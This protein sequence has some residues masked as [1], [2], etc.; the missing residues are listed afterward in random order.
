MK[1]CRDQKRREREQ[2]EAWAR[3]HGVSPPENSTKVKKSTHRFEQW[4]ERQLKANRET[5]AQS[6]DFALNENYFKSDADKAENNQSFGGSSSGG[7]VPNEAWGLMKNGPQSWAS[8]APWKFHI[9]VRRVVQFC[10]LASSGLEDQLATLRQANIQTMLVK[11]RILVDGASWVLCFLPSDFLEVACR[12]EINPD[13]LS[14]LA[15]TQYEEVQAKITEKDPMLL[16]SLV[17]PVDYER[18]RELP[19]TVFGSRSSGS[20]V[21]KKGAGL[22]PGAVL[23]K[24]VTY[25]DLEVQCPERDTIESLEG[26]VTRWLRTAAGRENDPN[27]PRS[28]HVFWSMQEYWGA[29]EQQEQLS[30]PNAGTGIQKL[31]SLISK[32]RAVGHQVYVCVYAGIPH[33]KTNPCED[34]QLRLFEESVMN[35]V[36]C[37]GSEALV[38][39]GLGFWTEH[40]KLWEDNGWFAI[41]TTENERAVSQVLDRYIM[42]Q[43]TILSLTIHPE[44]VE[45][46][47]NQV[48]LRAAGIRLLPTPWPVQG[49]T[50]P[51]QEYDAFDRLEPMIGQESDSM[52]SIDALLHDNTEI[53]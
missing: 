40:H 24:Y 42:R 44:C 43:K 4:L 33:I 2:N 19:I 12:A 5:L 26:L 7:P 36:N 18:M 15:Q 47:E 31:K 32:L 17:E 6:G 39:Q 53:Q 30:H 46:Y 22:T 41:T 1:D 38:D 10:L 48:M 11:Y 27:K 9:Y 23:N 28:V 34:K 50:V 37:G 20:H 14:P 51:E 49:E 16:R 3:I 25:S 52:Q 13:C 45:T 35:C 8:G 29:D 21:N